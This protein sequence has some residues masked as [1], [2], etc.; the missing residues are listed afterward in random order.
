MSKP[1]WE[2]TNEIVEQFII[3]EYRNW[4]VL[5]K[6]EQVRDITKTCLELALARIRKENPNFSDEELQFH[7]A[8]LWLDSETLRGA[9]EARRK[10]K[11]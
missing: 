2:D 6:L 7:L 4:S 1:L 11:G 10:Y 3:W 9:F 5:K 8:S